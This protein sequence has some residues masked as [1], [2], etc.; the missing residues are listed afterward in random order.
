MRSGFRDLQRQLV[1]DGHKL[2]HGLIAAEDVD[3]LEDDEKAK[4]AARRDRST[5]RRVEGE[6]E[7]QATEGSDRAGAGR[8]QEPLNKRL[9]RH[10]GPAEFASS[11]LEE[12][13]NLGFGRPVAARRASPASQTHGGVLDR[14]PVD[15]PSGVD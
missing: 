2:Q 11:G 5:R 4:D 3:A 14:I 10:Q 13:F 15:A 12:F 9:Q 8:Y 6:G 7:N 1:A